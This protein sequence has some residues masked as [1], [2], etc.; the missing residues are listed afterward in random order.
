MAH[1][2]G[3]EHDLQVRKATTINFFSY[4][5]RYEDWTGV[6]P[7]WMV[8]AWRCDLGSGWTD[9][10]RI[11]VENGADVNNYPRAGYG[12]STTVMGQAAEKCPTATVEYLLKAGASPTDGR[13]RKGTPLERAR[14]EEIKELLKK[15]GA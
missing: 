1:Q 5:C 3:F 10:I 11:F 13:G 8:V 14:N 4:S 15:Y 6:S 7:L 2:K 12:P 9:L